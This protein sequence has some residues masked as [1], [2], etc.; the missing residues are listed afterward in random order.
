MFI[1]IILC[2]LGVNCSSSGLPSPSVVKGSQTLELY[3]LTKIQSLMDDEY[4]SAKVF[5]TPLEEENHKD[6][7]NN[8][9]KPFYSFDKYSLIMDLD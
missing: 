9:S 1:F 7:F 8:V 5:A 3:Q 6:R 2:K 4:Q